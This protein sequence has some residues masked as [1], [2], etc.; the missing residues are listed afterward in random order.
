MSVRVMSLVWDNFKTGGSE[1]LAMLAMADW[2]NDQGGSLHP[3]M[4]AIADKIGLSEKQARRVIHSLIEQGYISVV[5]NNFGGDPGQSRLYRLNVE[6]LT[7]TPVEGRGKDATK[8]H[9]EV[10]EPLPPMSPLPCMG[11]LPPVS[12][13]PSHGCPS[14]PPAHG[15][16]TTSEPSVNHHRVVHDS[17][18]VPVKTGGG[19]GTRLPDD[20]IPDEE[21]VADAYRIQPGLNHSRIVEI[22]EGFRDYWVSVPGARGVKLDWKATWRNWVR[23]EKVS[24]GMSASDR[25]AMENARILEVLT[26]KSPRQDTK[27]AI[28]GVCHVA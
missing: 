27:P 16:L 26:G 7:T 4:R 5:G 3:S 2:C 14:T 8:N 18:S 6:K 20:W 13:D 25:K 21:S 12:I 17:E 9:P 19:R 22:A 24:H 28:E 15:S 10:I 1:K 23:R 11:P